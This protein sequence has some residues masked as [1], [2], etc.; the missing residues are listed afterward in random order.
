[1]SI[2]TDHSTRRKYDDLLQNGTLKDVTLRDAVLFCEFG[3]RRE[4]RGFDTD[5]FFFDSRK[6]IKPLI[7]IHL[8]QVMPICSGLA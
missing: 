2:V 3:D 8:T 6:R 4:H 1:M 7:G 5:Q